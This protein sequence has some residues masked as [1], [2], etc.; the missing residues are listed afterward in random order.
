MAVQ[1]LKTGSN[2]KAAPGLFVFAVISS[3]L[4][5]WLDGDLNFQA[6]TQDG[7]TQFL[8]CCEPGQ[9]GF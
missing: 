7:D 9:Y 3:L 4:F 1:W 6:V 8:I 2:T 5:T